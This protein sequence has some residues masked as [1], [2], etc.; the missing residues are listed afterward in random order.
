MQLGYR[1]NPES[2]HFLLYN[3]GEAEVLCVRSHV[4]FLVNKE[5][6]HFSVSSQGHQVFVYVCTYE[7][8]VN[9]KLHGTHL[10]YIFLNLHPTV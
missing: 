2:V 7:Y 4:H 10:K 3:C 9:T 1:G 8:T 5:H 6:K